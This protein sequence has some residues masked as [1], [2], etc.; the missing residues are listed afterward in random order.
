MK[1]KTIIIGAGPGGLTAGM[2][3]SQ[4]DRDVVVFEKESVPGGRN[5]AIKLGDYTFDTGP[6]FLM[7]PGILD[8]VFELAGNRK[9][10]DYM[11]LKEIEP[12]YRLSYDGQKELCPTRDREEMQR[13]IKEIF[14]GD[15]KGYIKFLKKEKVKFERLYKCLKI[16]YSNISHYLRS[17]FVRA[18]PYFNVPQ[19]LNSRLGKYFKNENMRISMAFQSKYLGMSPW[20]CPAAFTMISYIEH[21]F[22]IWH[23]IGGLNKIS[24][25]MAKVVIEN[26]GQINYNTVV[27]EIIV[28]DKKAVG[29]LLENGEEVYGEDIII[30]PDFAYS[31]TN[32]IDK[33]HRK[34]Y[35]DNDLEKRDYSCSTF[36]IY[37][38]VNKKFDIPHHN[39]VFSS[40]YRKNVFEI[41]DYKVLSEDPSFYIQNASKTDDTLAPEG[42]STIYILVPVPNN[43]SGIDWDAEKQSFRDKIIEGVK[44]KTELKD[45]EKHIEVEKIIT[46]NDWVK[47]YNVFKGATFNLSH[48]ITQMLSMRPQ[49]KFTEFDNC[50]LVGGGTHP[51]SGVPTILESGRIAAN[52]ILAGGK[53]GLKFN[54]KEVFKK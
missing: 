40:D 37:L 20:T 19:S 12:M 17:K 42:K 6:T 14:P 29:V 51:G 34:K 8:E 21:A 4:N 53:K 22:G 9:V 35:T 36:M 28:K 47:S 39:I 26:G 54:Y 13:R 11:D 3:L 45:I 33:K 2:L 32:L 38:G 44:K 27:K 50:Y 16:P 48:K 46:P 18:L 15:E 5:A 24:E 10:S 25:S 52:L 31:M 23:P 7:L 30:N 49:N 1:K 43:K 41:S